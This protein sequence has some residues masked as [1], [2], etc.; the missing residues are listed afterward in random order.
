ML[1]IFKKDLEFE[2]LKTRE[3]ETVTLERR[4]FDFG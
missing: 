1:P 3:S 4:I 2:L